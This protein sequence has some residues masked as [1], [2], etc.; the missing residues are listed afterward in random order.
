MISNVIEA[1]QCEITRKF[2]ILISYF[3][4]LT[5][6]WPKRSANLLS[7]KVD[8]VGMVSSFPSKTRLFRLHFCC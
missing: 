7:L 1:K 4:V 8:K 5:V 3:E 2:S 6:R